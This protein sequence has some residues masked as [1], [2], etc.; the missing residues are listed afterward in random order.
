VLE[1]GFVSFIEE[2]FA[3]VVDLK[4]KAF[5]FTNEELQAASEELICLFL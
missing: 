3:E 2:A 1:G 5:F 4:E